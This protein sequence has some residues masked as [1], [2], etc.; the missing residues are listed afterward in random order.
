MR[1][2]EESVILEK[3]FWKGYLRICFWG[4]E[5]ERFLNLCAHHSI[6][7]WQV[8]KHEEVYWGYVLAADFYRID[9]IRKKSGIQIKIKGKYGIPFF[10]YRNKKRKVFFIGIL[11]ALIAIFLL[12][13]RVWNIHV[14]GNLHNSTE[15]ILNYLETIHVWHGMRRNE[16]DCG[17]IAGELRKEFPDITWV[18][19]KLTGVR[20]MLEIKENESDQEEEQLKKDENPCDLRAK[21]DGIILSMIVRKGTA[22]KKIGENCSKNE[23]LVSGKV[24]MI[25]DS[26]EIVGEQM[27]QA[28]AD[29]EIKYKAEYYQE[30]SRTYQKVIPSGETRQGYMIQVGNYYLD[31]GRN[32]KEQEYNR[33]IRPQQLRLTENFKLPVFYGKIIDYAVEKK[34]KVYTKKEAEEKAEQTILRVLETLSQKGIQIS[35]NHVRIEVNKTRCVAKGSLI[36]IEKATYQAPLETERNNSVDEQYN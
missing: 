20:L 33:L 22:Q 35:E 27:V 3:K 11:F 29:I 12:S 36:L 16:L 5:S 18:S 7:I 6:Q 34:E 24:S 25:N 31:T 10:F 28:D 30:F 13:G 17:Y 19:A 21:K 2:R 26:Q 9:T 23:I 1:N 4:Q 14:E 32:L 15:S 8:E